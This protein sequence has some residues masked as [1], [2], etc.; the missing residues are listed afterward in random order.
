MAPSASQN[1]YATFSGKLTHVEV[2]APIQLVLFQ[3]QNFACHYDLL[4][5]FFNPSKK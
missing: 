2:S 5:F 1:L 3:E 4:F